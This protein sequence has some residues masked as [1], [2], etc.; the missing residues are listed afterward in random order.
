MRLRMPQL[1]RG[2]LLLPPGE[3]GPKGRMRAGTPKRCGDRTL[4]RRFA[5]PSPGG[6][7]TCSR[8]AE[9]RS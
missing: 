7:G 6:R 9:V 1:G 4:T 2:E 3:G 5:A 8:R